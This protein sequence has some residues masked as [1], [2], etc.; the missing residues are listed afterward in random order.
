MSLLVIAYP[1][2]NTTDYNQIQDCRAS[3]DSLYFNIVEPHF[4]FVFPVPGMDEDRFI[5]EIES[6][7]ANTKSIQFI[8]RSA[9]I[10]KDAFSDYYHIFLVP[11]EGN[12]R[13][14]RLHDKLYRGNLQSQLR[15]DIAYIPHITIG[16]STD[17]DKCKALAEQWNKEEFAFPGIIRQLS[18]VRFENT[19]VT[20]LKNIPLV[21]E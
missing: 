18:I 6:K 13:M 17:A 7:A 9:T 12:G 21:Q 4:T 16:N 2:F 19:M 3:Q 10:H 8:L 14:I 20:N 1:E 15:L 11:D 5:A